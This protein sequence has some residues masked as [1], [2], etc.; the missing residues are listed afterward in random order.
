MAI[1]RSL[2]SSQ[3]PEALRLLAITIRR[4]LRGSETREALRLLAMTIRRLF[5][6]NPA[7]KAI[8]LPTMTAMTILLLRKTIRILLFTLPEETEVR[9]Q[10]T[11]VFSKRLTSENM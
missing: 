2:Y 4:L 9:R 8:L 3:G 10:E 7:H 6:P 11:K 5:R 1:R